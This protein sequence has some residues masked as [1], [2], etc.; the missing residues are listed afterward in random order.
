M[1]VKMVFFD[2]LHTIVRPRL[3][4][5]IQYAEVFAPHFTVD[6]LQIK[7]AFKTGPCI[8]GPRRFDQIMTDAIAAALKQVQVERPAYVSNDPQSAKRVEHWWSE[9]IR[10]TAIGAGADLRG[11]ALPRLDGAGLTV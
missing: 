11:K 1:R 4:I 8:H 2:A 9:V 10:R 7:A 3:P 6:P 5:H